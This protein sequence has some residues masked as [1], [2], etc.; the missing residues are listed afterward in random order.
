M[1]KVKWAVINSIFLAMILMGTIGNIEG[2]QNVAVLWV[3]IIFV[4][5]FGY[6]SKKVREEVIKSGTHV[7]PAWANYAVSI[8]CLALM[9]W[10]GWY[11]TSAAFV[12]HIILFSSLYINGEKKELTEPVFSVDNPDITNQEGANGRL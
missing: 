11:W 8:P 7:M 1:R 12:I 4:I 10:F 9:A 5:S 3:W 6:L 2:A